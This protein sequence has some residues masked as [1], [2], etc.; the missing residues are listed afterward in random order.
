MS[1]NSNS[2]YYQ[3]YEELKKSKQSYIG[4]EISKSF[5]DKYHYALQS[6]TLVPIVEKITEVDE[7]RAAIVNTYFEDMAKNICSQNVVK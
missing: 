3:I 4:T 6:E 1:N 7:K 5:Y 2:K